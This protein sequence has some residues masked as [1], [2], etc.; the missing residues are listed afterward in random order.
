MNKGVT[1]ADMRKGFHMLD[2]AGIGYY[3]TVILGLGGRTFSRL[4]AI[5]TAKF[6]NND[7][8][9]RYLVSEASPVP[10]DSS[11]PRE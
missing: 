10:G 3:V 8:S 6:L 4:H 7:P 5:E 2:R 1:S 9:K 11:V